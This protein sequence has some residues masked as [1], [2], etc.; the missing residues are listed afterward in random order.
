[1]GHAASKTAKA[2][3]AAAARAP[4]SSPAAQERPEQL[5][6]N[7]TKLGQVAVESPMVLQRVP[8]S[9]FRKIDS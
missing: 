7:L 2:G 9:T 5:L 1:M 3:A 4:K 8:D 6:S